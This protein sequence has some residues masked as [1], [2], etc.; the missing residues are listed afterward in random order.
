MLVMQP[1]LFFI[2]AYVLTV[3]LTL[4]HSAKNQGNA[5]CVAAK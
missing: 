1:E 2:A 3:A 4:A 5:G